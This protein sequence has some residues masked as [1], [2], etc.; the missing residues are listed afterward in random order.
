MNSRLAA[1]AIVAVAAF[2]IP[3]AAVAGP[4][5]TGSVAGDAPTGCIFDLDTTTE[6]G[7]G[8]GTVFTG[9]TFFTTNFTAS[10]TS[11]Y[12]SFAFRESPAYFSFDD[13]CVVAGST[14][15]TS[16]ACG[17][18]LG[19]LLTNVAFQGSNVG[20]NC[21]DQ[22][23]G[24][25]CPVGWGAWIQSVDL[26]AIGE[27]VNTGNTGGCGVPGAP[28]TGSATNTWWCDGSVEGYDAI[29]QQLTS[30]TVGQ[31]Y[32]VG[33][34]LDDNSAEGVTE[35]PGSSNQVDMLVYAGTALPVGSIPIG[36]PPGTTP[37]PTTYALVGLG[38]VA[39]GAI[40]ARKSRKA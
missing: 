26:D 2:L 13:A 29:Y 23:S 31:T 32:Q 30:L 24:T 22:G 8:D 36:N 1:A 27:I 10:A 33:W 18:S 4:A 14:A 40:R 25:P 3:S 12:V 11:E 9:Y 15:V 28:P 16:A 38:L 5:C 37:E 19:G 35:T 17:S 21:N 7:G 6:A 39:M 20:D 34:W